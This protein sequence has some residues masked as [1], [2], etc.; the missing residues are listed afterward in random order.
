MAF[1]QDSA[2][3]NLDT[4]IQGLSHIDFI[5]MDKHGVFWIGCNQGLVSYDPLLSNIELYDYNDNIQGNRFLNQP[6]FS[7]EGVMF[8]GGING[9]NYFR[10]E[11]M[12][13]S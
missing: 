6:L 5:T 1:S 2:E 12:K 10:P 11:K 4:S 7:Q 13:A 3:I 9:I 8:I